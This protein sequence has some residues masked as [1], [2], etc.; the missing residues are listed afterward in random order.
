MPRFGLSAFFR[1]VADLP[2]FLAASY[3][4]AAGQIAGLLN[5]LDKGAREF[6]HFEMNEPRLRQEEL[7]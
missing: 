5:K 3:C 6:S 7:A 4:A 1:F 2:F